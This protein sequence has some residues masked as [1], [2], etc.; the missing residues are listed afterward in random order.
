MKSSIGFDEIIKNKL[1][2]GRPTNPTRGSYLESAIQQRWQRIVLLIV[3]GY[4]AVGALS[5]G[6]LLIAVPDGRVMHMQADIMHGV[7]NDFL[8][9]GFILFGLGMLSAVAFLAVLYRTRG[10]WVWGVFAIVGLLIWFLVE[11]AI[12]KETHWLHFMWGFPVIV[13][14]LMMLSLLPF[15]QESIRKS[16]LACG[17]LS[18]FLFIVLDVISVMLYKGYNPWSQTLT[19][20]SALGSPTGPLWL[21]MMIIYTLLLIGFSWGVLLSSA[22]NTRLR[23]AACFF[24]VYLVISFFRPP[25]YQSEV[26]STGGSAFADNLHIVF[27]ILIV[28][29][30]LL[31]IKSGTKIFRKGFQRYSMITLLVLVA[32]GILTALGKEANQPGELKSLV[33]VWERINTGAFLLWI[34]MLAIILINHEK[35]KHIL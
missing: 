21:L 10:D 11:I 18:S 12:L 26:L 14:A 25:I 35:P 5:G 16:M 32:F 15:R 23:M 22:G 6:A 24:F 19:E 7:F 4:E 1:S 31:A 20:L 27:R 3:L 2:T 30:M 8:I 28:S 9:P 17:I 29:V 13:G 34:I 33:G